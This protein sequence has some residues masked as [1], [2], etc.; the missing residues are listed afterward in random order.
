ML[1][2]QTHAVTAK[3]LA[4]LAAR[5]SGAECLVR[6][7]K[8]G[9]LIVCEQGDTPEGV[10]EKRVTP[11]FS[12]GRTGPDAG[13]WIFYV[14]LWTPKEWRSEFCAWYRCEHAEILLECPDWEGFQF[15][16]GPSEKGCQFYVLH[17]LA[18][19]GA[20]DSEW[21]RLSRSTSWFKRLAK[22]KWFDK[23]FERVLYRRINIGLN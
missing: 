11:L 7:D 21:R 16:E 6:E 1:F 18:E 3:A 13:A 17:H 15:L 4:A 19:R 23:P 9:S 8:T 10:N 5:A 12:G 20:L 22:N 14:G 2:W